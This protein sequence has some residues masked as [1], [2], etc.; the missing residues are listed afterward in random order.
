MN[1]TFRTIIPIP[2]N[3][4]SIELG[5]SI[6]C[7]GS[8]FAESI[9]NKLIENCFKI[10]VN[11]FG[12]LFNPL[13]IAQNLGRLLACKNFSGED[14]FEHN[15]LW[16]SFAHHGSFSG[17]DREQCLSRINDSFAAASATIACLDTLIVTL[18]TSWV[19]VERS[20]GSVVANCHKLPDNRF[21]R[22]LASIDEIVQ[23]LD[24][25]FSDLYSSR[26]MANIILTVSPV[27]HLRDNAHE[28]SVSKAYLMAAA[29]EL[30]KRFPALYYFPAYEIMM[31]ELRDYRFYAADMTH[32][33]DSAIDYISERFQQACLS[34]RSRSFALRLAPILRAARHRMS[35][36][37]SPSGEAFVA[38]RIQSV[39]A[40][41]AEFPEV[42]LARIDTT[43]AL[44]GSARRAP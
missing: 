7:M 42:D 14:L 1:E 11:P 41:H 34:D 20:S 10:C 29:G 5:H 23:S 9:G 21:E 33:S 12:P 15:E 27:R 16:H 28:N 40:L 39:A 37:G 25:I 36:V 35:Q 44:P 2:A 30:E 6:L 18:G 32:P 31:D 22:R 4:R 17:I 19:Y 8:C 38:S 43:L 24:S 26:P 13:S 3:P